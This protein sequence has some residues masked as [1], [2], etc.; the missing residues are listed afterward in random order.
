[1]FGWCMW[2]FMHCAVGI[3]GEDVANRVAALAHRAVIAVGRCVAEPACLHRRLPGLMPFLAFA[4]MRFLALMA[5]GV[6]SWVGSRW[7]RSR[8]VRS[9]VAV[10]PSRPYWA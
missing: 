10:W 3:A 4:G 8:I 1:M 9:T 6:A 2:Q 7:M 5:F